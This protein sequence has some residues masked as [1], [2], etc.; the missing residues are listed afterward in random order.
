MSGFDLSRHIANQT[1]G[2][3]DVI[4]IPQM[5]EILGVSR[6][7]LN[8]YVKRGVFLEPWRTSKGRTIGWLVPA[9][10]EWKKRQSTI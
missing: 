5:C 4:R 7:T 6:Q 9:F 3:P 1:G 2:P 10:E 8:R